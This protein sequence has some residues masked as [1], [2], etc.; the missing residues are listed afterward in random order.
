MDNS[1][2]KTKNKTRN[3]NAPA[4]TAKDHD[5]VCKTMLTSQPRHTERKF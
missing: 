2:C 1:V 4:R 3:T 5:K